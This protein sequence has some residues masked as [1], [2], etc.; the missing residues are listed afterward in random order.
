MLFAAAWLAIVI[1]YTVQAGLRRDG[2]PANRPIKT[3]ASDYVSSDS[4]RS[5]HPGNYASWHASFHRT[6]TQVVN[7]QT[8]PPG[9]DGL[10]LSYAGKDYHVAR[11]GDDFFVRSKPAGAPASAFDAPRQ[12]VLLTGSHHLQILWLETGEQ[13]TLGQFPLAYM[14]EEK[15]WTPVQHTFLVPP[16]REEALYAKGDWNVSCMNCHVTQGRSRPSAGGKFDSRAVDFGIACEACH[17]GGREHIEAN[18][19][20]LRRFAL[21]LFGGAD[22]TIANPARMTGPESSLVCGQCHSI[23]VYKNPADH[24]TWNESGGKYRPGQKDLDLRWV[25]QPRGDD[26]VAERAALNQA[27]AHFFQDQFWPDGMVRVIGRELNAVMASPCYQGRHY[28]CI[29]CHE[30]HPTATDPESLAT[31]ARTSQKKPGA[32]ANHTCTQCHG[33][34][35]SDAAL[36]A[37]THHAAGSEGSN[38]YNCHM[39]KTIYGLLKATRSHQISSPSA[40]ETAEMG[41]P[42]ACNLCHLNQTLAWTSDQLSQWY[43]Q[44]APALSA[45]DRQIATGV[46]WVLKG[47]ARQRAIAVLAM[48]WAPAQQAA[49]RDWLYP[50][51]IFELND[52]YSVVRY[53]A[54]KSLQSLPGFGDFQFDYVADDATQKDAV[55]EAYRQWWFKVRGTGAIYPASTILDPTGMFRQDVFDRLLNLRDQ[56]KVFIAE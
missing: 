23:W 28:S 40:R 42:N 21:H 15:R 8:V 32:D 30:M 27:D 35:A 13:R 5:C 53:G 18:R 9:M 20:P 49:G 3:L 33:D 47:D 34:K 16:D 12:I 24:R 4:C 51:L 45:E 46:Q 54:W 14:V 48:G 22:A 36:I 11:Q 50:F 56:R 17:A 10:D 7:R 39:P 41:R 6:M 2:P 37:H 26:H 29:S 43:K 38:C 44:P 1:V 55:T 25:A 31:W 19:N 52:P